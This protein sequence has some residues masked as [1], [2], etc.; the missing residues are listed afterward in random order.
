MLLIPAYD[1][2]HRANGEDQMPPAGTNALWKR[3][4]GIVLTGLHQPTTDG[5]SRTT[6]GSAT[7]PMASTIYV[8]F[9][10]TNHATGFGNSHFH[11]IAVSR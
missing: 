8:G 11:D 7:V 10:R 9:A 5:V 2:C 1:P 3:T 4:P 6:I